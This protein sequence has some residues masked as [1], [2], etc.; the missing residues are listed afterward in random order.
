MY[1]ITIFLVVVGIGI[2]RLIELLNKDKG[3]YAAL[4]LIILL[5]VVPLSGYYSN[6]HKEDWRGF[7]ANL[8]KITQPGD[9]IVPLPGYM[10]YPLQYYYSNQSDKTFLKDIAYNEA[11]F[12][13]LEDET[14]SVYFVVTW[15]IQAA[16]PSGYSLQYLKENAQQQSA[17]V[18]GINLLK[19][20]R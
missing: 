7:S 5:S 13:S 20:V 9:I 15:D 18:P 14:G 4:V 16:D 10:V 11:G 1:L 3:V 12:K 19:K 6:L 8:Q 17:S 2:G